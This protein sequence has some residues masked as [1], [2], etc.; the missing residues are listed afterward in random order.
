MLM[1][2]RRLS[3]TNKNQYDG[4]RVYAWVTTASKRGDNGGEGDGE[5]G[6][7]GNGGGKVGRGVSPPL[8]SG[9][10]DGGGLGGGIGGGGGGVAHTRGTL[11]GGMGG[12]GGLGG[13]DGYASMMVVVGAERADRL[14][15]PWYSSGRRACTIS[16]PASTVN[17]DTA[18]STSARAVG[19]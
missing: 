2:G 13:Y 16:S 19:S 7:V 6:G 5:G 4:E 1:D 11:H 17:D 14:M 12:G 18:A 8:L 10:G 9:D 3:P 15:K